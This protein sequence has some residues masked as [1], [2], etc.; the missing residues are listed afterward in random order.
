MHDGSESLASFLDAVAAR[1]PTPGGGAVAA[2]TGAL[3]CAIGEMALNYSVDKKE[4]AAHRD[5]LS[6]A[7][8]HLARARALLLRLLVEDQEAYTAMTAAR[9]SGDPAAT[10]AA[11]LAAIRVPQAIAATGAAVLE[12]AERVAPVA[13]RWL[14]SDLAV[15]VELAM[16]TVRCGAHN[17]RVNLG[18]LPDAADAHRFREWCDDIIARAV[19]R[20]C[21]VMPEVWRRIEAP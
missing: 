5:V 21:R 2:V 19:Q 16:A 8:A 4:L 10:Q 3:A 15:A 20:V 6:D 18:Q 14:L 9:K 1:Q 12:Q 7:L 17:V 13:N 11:L